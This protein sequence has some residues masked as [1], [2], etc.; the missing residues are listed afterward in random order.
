MFSIFAG[1]ET[2][3]P[4]IFRGDRSPMGFLSV[5]ADNMALGW[6]RNPTPEDGRHAFALGIYRKNQQ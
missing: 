4:V 3:L 1:P 2:R 5:V 6:R